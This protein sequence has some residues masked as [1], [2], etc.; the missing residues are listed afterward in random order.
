MENERRP[1]PKSLPSDLGGGLV[2][3]T[4]SSLA[5]VERIASL[6]AAVHCD[7]Q[8]AD[9]ARWKLAGGHP[10]V[11]P[12]NAVLVE[13]VATGEV[14]SSLCSFPQ[15]WLYDGVLLPVREIALVGTAPRYRK[16]GLIR[17]QMRYVHSE[18]R[19][20]GDLL[21]CIEGIPG[22]YRQFG[23]EFAVPLGSCAR[24]TLDKL[25][26]NEGL[27][28]SVVTRPI[29]LSK[30][31]A[32]V[33]S[34]YSASS[35]QF[36]ILAERSEAL[37]QYLE[38]APAGI[39][40]SQETWVIEVEARVV[41]YFRLRKNMWGPWL[42]L[43]EMCI[44]PTWDVDGCLALYKVMLGA[45]RK[46]AVE[47][48]Y[49]GLCFA[50]DPRHELLELVARLGSEADRQYAWQVKVFNA[51]ELLKRIAPV[52]EKRLQGSTC[53]DGNATLDINLMPD[54][55]RIS[56]EHG[57][58]T[59]VGW[60]RDRAAAECELRLTKHQFVQ[61]VLGYRD[62]ATLMDGSLDAWVHPQVRGLVGTLFPRLRALI[63]GA[64]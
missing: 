31:L 44:D 61:L 45:S 48:D 41:A 53:T 23:Y 30:D 59:G 19:A 63:N 36:N 28:G 42:E 9:Y 60:Q 27:V 46:I 21:G 7:E 16:R 56:I 33:M 15:T 34:L 47:R 40:D 20:A 26:V 64:D 32:A 55:V 25:P 4:A 8:V 37:W 51:V 57:R 18:M 1:P 38:A 35:D 11:R 10:A 24:L 14:V 52:L 2:M 12:S 6:N 62:Y 22:F 54:V 13:D 39:P 3:R 17:A 58:V 29:N 5:D 43:A 50:L 49:Q